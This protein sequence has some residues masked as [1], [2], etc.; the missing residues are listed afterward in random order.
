MLM[1]GVA[2]GGGDDGGGD[3]DKAGSGGASAGVGGGSSGAGGSVA[4]G[5]GGNGGMGG[6]GSLLMCP[7]DPAIAKCGS[8]TCEPVAANLAM[9]CVQNC[10]TSDMKC[11]TLNASPVGTKMCAPKVD[12]DPD[13]PAV[14]ILGMN[15]PGCC[16]DDKKTCGVQDQTDWRLKGR[17]GPYTQEVRAKPKDATTK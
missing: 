16:M 3:K 8:E 7:M 9:I 4:T 6:V 11:G 2:C 14:S 5:T 10:C 17:T 1:T 12:E 15:I 13:C